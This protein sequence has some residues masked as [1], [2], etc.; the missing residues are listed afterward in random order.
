MSLPA[1]ADELDLGVSAQGVAIVEVKGG[2][3]A[4]IGFRKGDILLEVNG[5][6]VAM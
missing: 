3:A 2:P 1:L 4:Q 5:E 6:K